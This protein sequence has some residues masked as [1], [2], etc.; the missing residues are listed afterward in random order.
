MLTWFLIN[1]TKAVPSSNRLT[2]ITF[3]EASSIPIFAPFL[4]IMSIPIVVPVP[5][6]TWPFVVSSI[7][8]FPNAV[9]W[10]N[11]LSYT[12]FLI[13]SSPYSRVLPH[14]HALYGG[15]ARAMQGIPHVLKTKV[16][17]IQTYLALPP[18]A[19][20]SPPTGFLSQQL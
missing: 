3:G 18:H 2:S 13:R 12:R 10:K 20:I 1:K 4:R 8:V 17:L 7:L 6:V 9:N 15:L 19:P 5:V 16:F 11:F 14:Y